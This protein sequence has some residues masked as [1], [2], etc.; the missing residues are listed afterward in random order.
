MLPVWSD[1]VEILTKTAIFD[2]YLAIGSMTGGG[3]I[4]N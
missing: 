1:P 2:K 3:A 4:N